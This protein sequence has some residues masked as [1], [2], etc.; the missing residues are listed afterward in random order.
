[1][2]LRRDGRAAEAGTGVTIRQHER[3]R[4]QLHR[5]NVYCKLL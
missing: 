1:M 2:R 4:S 5:G 3:D